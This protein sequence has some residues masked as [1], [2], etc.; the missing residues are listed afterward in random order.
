MGEFNI[1]E[2]EE[3]EE[4]RDD[5]VEEESIKSIGGEDVEKDQHESKRSHVSIVEDGDKAEGDDRS[6]VRELDEENGDRNVDEVGEE[7]SLKETSEEQ[8][9]IRHPDTVEN[10]DMSE[11]LL[12]VM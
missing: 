8:L 12:K 10:I 9:K 5:I 2:V 6:S 4:Q 7:G 11:S 1:A 3:E